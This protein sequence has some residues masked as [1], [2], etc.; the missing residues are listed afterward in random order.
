[1]RMEYQNRLLSSLPKSEINRLQENLEAVALPQNMDLLAKGEK[2]LYAY[3]LEEGMASTVMTMRN[4]I[5]V[6]VGVTGRDG[7]VGMPILFGIDQVPTRTFM[8]IAGHGFRIKSQHLRTAFAGSGKVRDLCGKSLQSYLVQVSSTAACNRLHNIEERLAK[9]LLL[10]QDRT[11][12]EQLA[13]T[14]EFLSQMLGTGRANVTLAAG[15]L[16][17]SNLILYSR[18]KVAITDRKGLQKAA[19]ECYQVVRSE[20]DRLGVL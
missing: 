8:Q 7:V 15:I 18:G 4:G 9:W 1:M 20:D 14:H 6:E 5:T 16:Q 11:G 17:R 3:F 13:L 10:C 12:S 19:C 2:I